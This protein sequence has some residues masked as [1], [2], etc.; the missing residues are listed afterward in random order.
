[1]KTLVVLQPSYLPWLGFFDQLRQSDVF[2]YYDDVQFDKHGWRNR[3][4]IKSPLGKPHWL[5]VPVLHSG[6]NWPKVTD[7]EIDHTQH[8]AKK[9]LRTIF[10]FYS[11][12]PYLQKY[13]PEISEILLSPWKKLI[14]LNLTLVQSMCRWFGLKKKIVRASELSISGEQSERLIKICEHFSANRYLSGDAAQSY[15]DTIAFSK[16]GIEVRWHQYNHPKYNQLHGTFIP[17]L[18]ALDLFFNMG[19]QSAEVLLGDEEFRGS[20]LSG[21]INELLAKE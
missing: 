16:K 1:M 2:V 20:Q 4:R 5:T 6:K 14:D 15:L 17:Y 7:I 9:Q 11:R 12:A 18:S 21:H 3:N 10:Q 13:F 8:W 19:D